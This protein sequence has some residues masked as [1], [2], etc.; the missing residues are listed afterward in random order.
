M[1][2]APTHPSTPPSA[3]R[4][5]AGGAAR[6]V[7][8]LLLLTAVV[9]A[10]SYQLDGRLVRS[11][12][13]LPMAHLPATAS[14]TAAAV[15]EGAEDPLPAYWAASPHAA[16]RAKVLVV[17]LDGVR[18]DAL[19]RARTPYLDMLRRHGG[20]TDDARS[21]RTAP[22]VSAPGWASI[23]TGVE[24][25]R[26]G[27]TSNRAVGSWRRDHATFLQRASDERGAT[28]QA[29]V[30]WQPLRRLIEDTVPVTVIPDDARLCEAAAAS[31]QS[32]DV[33][34]TFVHFDDPDHA[35]HDEGGFLPTN[36]RYL[37]AIERSDA[38]LGRL[39]GAI[40]AREGAGAESWRVIVTT[41]HGGDAHGHGGDDED[42]QRVFVLSAAPGA[43]PHAL[44]EGTTHMVVHDLTLAHLPARVAEGGLGAA[45]DSG[46]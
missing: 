16:A 8:W 30:H 1:L 5:T 11:A 17:G 10:A 39:L 21:Q 41:D 45:Q 14:V 12:T 9:L 7:R 19:R 15:A 33:D 18:P 4:P 25:A 2:H 22:A 32:D 36:P 42:N 27:V 44:P 20:F 31:L 28:A 3:L 37:H 26:H 6:R 13:M 38:H 29:F 24:A 34:V 43:E 23:L 35:G 46:L 40:A